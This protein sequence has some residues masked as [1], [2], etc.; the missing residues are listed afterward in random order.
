MNNFYEVAWIHDCHKDINRRMSRNN[1][2]IY[3]L[4]SLFWTFLEQFLEVAAHV[5][6]L[7]KCQLS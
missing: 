2:E 5:G 4:N 7:T 6:Y 1:E 3:S